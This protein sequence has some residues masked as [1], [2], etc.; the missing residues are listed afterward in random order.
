MKP[1]LIIFGGFAGGG[2]TTISKRVAD[3]YH[4]LRL[5]TDETNTLLR[6]TLQLDFDTV[7]PFAHDL[8]WISAKRHLADGHAVIVDAPM[9]GARAWK[10]VDD[11]RAEFPR[12]SIVPIIL[13]CSLETHKQ[14]IEHRGRTDK[15]HLNLGGKP[16]DET[17]HKYAY[18][19]NLTRPDLIRVNAE[20]TPDEVYQTVVEQL[21]EFLA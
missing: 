20:G 21:R 15:E 1:V 2:K 18:I 5:S 17:V 9:C 19:S 4:L 10:N 13:E 14:R 16:F 12:V 11:V 7:S 6:D 8:V 3:A